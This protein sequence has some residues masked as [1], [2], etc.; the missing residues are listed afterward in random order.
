MRAGKRPER[1]GKV[2]DMNRKAATLGLLAAVFVGTVLAAE[3]PVPQGIPHL[4]HVC[5]II[6]ENHG[7]HQIVDNPDAPFIN[8]LAKSANSAT[9][10]FAIA[11]PSLTKLSGSGGRIQFW[12]A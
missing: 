1:K 10:Y 11:H 5:V 8:R 7:Y 2:N 4:D 3:G 9:N 6:M 12:R